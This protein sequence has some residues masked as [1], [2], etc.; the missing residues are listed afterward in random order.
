MAASCRYLVV[1]AFCNDI[2]YKIYNN[3]LHTSEVK[4][5]YIYHMFEY[6]SV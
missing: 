4:I 6:G 5:F 2:K 1:H 3:Q